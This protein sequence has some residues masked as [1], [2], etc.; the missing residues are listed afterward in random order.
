MGLSPL[1]TFYSLLPETF[2]VDELGEVTQVGF[3][4][5]VYF[6]PSIHLEKGW[7]PA[8]LKGFLHAGGQLMF[9]MPY[10]TSVLP[11]VF[12][13]LGYSIPLNSQNR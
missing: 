3:P 13:E 11:L 6:A 12:I 10:N 8:A 9:L 5:R 7:S 1:G 4:R 2:E